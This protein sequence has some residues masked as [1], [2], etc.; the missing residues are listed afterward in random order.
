VGNK[1]ENYEICERCGRE[2]PDKLIYEDDCYFCHRLTDE[3][4][5]K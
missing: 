5:K 2:S 1:I 4:L 3:E